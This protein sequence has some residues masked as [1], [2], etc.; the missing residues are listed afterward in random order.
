M[1]PAIPLREYITNTRQHNFYKR[2]HAVQTWDIVHNVKETF[3]GGVRVQMT[4]PEALKK[5]DTFVDPSDPDV[6]EPN[7][8]HAYQT[9]ERIRHKYGGDQK[10]LQVCGLIHDLGKILFTTGIDP[11]FVVG[12]TFVVGCAFPDTIVYPETMMGNPDAHHPVYGTKMGVYDMGCGLDALELSYGHD[13]YLY[14]MLVRN[15]DRHRLSER[16]MR[17]I[18]YHSFYP[19]HDKGSYMEFM[20]DTDHELLKDVKELNDHDLYSNGEPFELNY[21]MKSYYEELLN[22]YFPIALEW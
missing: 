2:Q 17:A 22:D 7:S 10:E 14:Q 16:W 12:D 19:W 4:V 15:R 13:E 5:L 6:D 1:N 18:R 11:T 3:K 8:I 21:K 9:A 20:D